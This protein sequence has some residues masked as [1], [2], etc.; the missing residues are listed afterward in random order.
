MSDLTASVRTTGTTTQV[1]VV[2][3]STSV[4]ADPVLY[5]QGATVQAEILARAGLDADLDFVSAVVVASASLAGIYYYTLIV[6][7]GDTPVGTTTHTHDATTVPLTLQDTYDAGPA[8]VLDSTLGPVVLSHT[9]DS[10]VDYLRIK[11]NTSTTPRDVLWVQQAGIVRHG[12]HQE[13]FTDATYDIGTPDGGTTLRRPRD[14]RLSRDLYA[15]GNAA[16]VGY[17]DFTSYV[18]A[19]YSRYTAQATNPD[20]TP[21]N[22]HVYVNSTDDSLRYWDGS[23]DIIISGGS[24]TSGDTVGLYSC[25]AGIVIGNAVVCTSADTVVAAN[26]GTLAGGT[27]AGIVVNKPTATICSVKYLGETGAVFGGGLTPGN[28]Y[29]LAKTDGGITDN[30]TTFTEGDTDLSVGFAKDSDTLLV[31]IGFPSIR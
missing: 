16:V 6:T 10:S 19:Q 26:A 20:N 5:V 21:A 8:I 1:D 13:F 25:A 4:I 29:F 14:I 31:R 11:T 2:I 27:I 30:T 9:D 17:G 3:P 22:R 18:L 28:E 24:G 15:G 23:S 7:Y 12:A